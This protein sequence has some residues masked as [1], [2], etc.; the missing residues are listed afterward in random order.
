MNVPNCITLSRLV[1]IVAFAISYLNN[2]SMVAAVFLVVIGISDILDGFFARKLH[3]E[4]KFGAALD[5]FID[6][7]LV[8]TIMICFLLHN[9]VSIYLIAIYVVKDLIMIIGSLVITKKEDYNIKANW[10]GKLS[11]VLF[12]GCVLATI[13]FELPRYTADML[14]LTSLAISLIA[15]LNYVVMF[16]SNLKQKRLNNKK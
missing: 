3:Q 8:I 1:F 14:L 6:K 2:Y 5:P 13:V 9:V 11:A 12:F 16:F 7:C 10:L 4:S 15:S